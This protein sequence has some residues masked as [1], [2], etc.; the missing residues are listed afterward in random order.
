MII[1]I[2]AVAS[3]FLR[4]D[5]YAVAGKMLES[6]KR[7]REKTRKH[8]LFDETTTTTTTTNRGFE[9]LFFK[10]LIYSGALNH[11]KWLGRMIQ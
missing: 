11:Q 1:I 4:L 10:Q 8:R 2:A 3:S 6:K 7:G 5:E 9:E